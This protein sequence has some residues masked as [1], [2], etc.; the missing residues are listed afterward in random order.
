MRSEPTG[1]LETLQQ[2][3]PPLGFLGVMTCLWGDPSPVDAPEAPPDPLQ[4]AAVMEPTVVTMS[5]SCIVKD[6]ANGVTYMDTMTT[7]VGQ[8]ALSGP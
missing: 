4:L 1:M 7:S 2:V 5:T 3:M 6:E 8:V